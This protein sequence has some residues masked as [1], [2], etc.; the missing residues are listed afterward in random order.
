MGPQYKHHADPVELAIEA[1]TTEESRDNARVRE[2]EGALWELAKKVAR[3]CRT[4]PRTGA[5]HT[6]LN[7]A[8]IEAERAL[9]GKKRGI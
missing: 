1:L 9:E 3:V 6:Y 7:D 5:L 2:L 8:R 4:V